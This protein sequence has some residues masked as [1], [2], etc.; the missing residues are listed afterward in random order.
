M[1][2]RIA[3][4]LWLS[5]LV[6]VLLLATVVGFAGLRSARAQVES[7]AIRAAMKERVDT[8]MVWMGLTRDNAT[9]TLATVISSDPAGEAAP[10]AGMASTSEQISALQKKMQTLADSDT[11]RAQI[12]KIA[13][14]R[15]AMAQAR[16]QVRKLKAD[17]QQAEAVA[18]VEK[19]YRPAS[20]AYLKTLGDFLRLQQQAEQDQLQRVADSRATTIR[21][22]VSAMV[23]LMLAIGAGA[24]VLIRSIQQPLQKA[25]ALAGRIAAGDLSQHEEIARQDEFGELLRSLYAMSAAL[26]RTVQQVRHSTDS[27]AT[28]SA[29]IASGNHDLSA[30]T[31]QTS[32][33]LQQ[34]A[35]AMDQFT[36]TIQ[37]SAASAQQA[38]SLAASATG[39]ARR[40]GEVVTQVVAT[41]DEITQSSKKIADIIG[42]IDGIAFQTNILA[43]NAAVEAARAGEQ[44]RGFAVVASEVRSLAGR[45]A[46][47]AKEI[48]QLIGTSVDRVEAGSRL[49]QDAGTTMQ[50]IVQS[51]QRVTDMIG[52]I[53]AASAEQSAGIAQVNQSVGN[54]DQMTQQ[55]AALV[56]ESAAAAQSLREQAEQLAQVVAT[57]K[58]AGGPAAMAAAPAPH[59]APRPPAVARPSAPVRLPAAAAPAARPAPARPP[60]ARPLPRPAPPSAA[61]A[62]SAGAEGDWESF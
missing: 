13:Q 12:A 34:T 17:G 8:A 21:V 19:T 2:F 56:E 59:P 35:A 50:D 16:D 23:L 44:G 43:L 42:V 7:D 33:N 11:D 30:R 9:R 29:E 5:V 61:K 1:Q 15:S 3:H 32:S 18:F 52:E 14:A 62:P 41:M 22:G 36:S 45:S 48:K 58:L 31:E 49:V 54:L 25:N 6:L 4:K 10:K 28:A 40:G 60:A 55:N 46:E 20:D 38:S 47:A 24:F 57:F 53:T 27:I 39:V 37:Q 51:V 26:A